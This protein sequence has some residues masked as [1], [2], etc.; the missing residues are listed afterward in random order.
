VDAGT[1][2]LIIVHHTIVRNRPVV[3]TAD[4]HFFYFHSPGLPH[5]GSQA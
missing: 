3:V 2:F 5:G 1:F 4:Q